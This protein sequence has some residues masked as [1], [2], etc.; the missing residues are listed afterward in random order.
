MI[1]KQQ[2][3]RTRTMRRGSASPG[4]RS[5]K[6]CIHLTERDVRALTWIGQQYVVCLDQIQHILG[7]EAPVPTKE[8][9]RLT[10]KRTRATVARWCEAGLVRQQKI[11]SSHHAWVWLSLVG[12]QEMGLSYRSHTPPAASLLHC[13]YVNQAR[14][15]IESG[16]LGEFGSWVSERQLRSEQQARLRGKSRSHVVDGELRLAEG[17]RVAIEVELTAKSPRRLAAIVDELAGR[18]ARIWYFADEPCRTLVEAVVEQLEPPLRATFSIV[19]LAVLRGEASH[20]Q[21]RRDE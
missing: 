20:R 2:E 6:G 3:A 15:F 17:G 7:R 1:Q 4:Y 5:D 18:Y 9:G 10:H 13:Y 16:A 11:L 8:P 14:L 12:L 19:S 21:G